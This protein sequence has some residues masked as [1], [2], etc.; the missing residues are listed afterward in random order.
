MGLGRTIFFASSMGNS[1]SQKGHLAAILS[2]S[3]WGETRNSS[4]QPGQIT[5]IELAMIILLTLL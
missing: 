1:F 4:S 5:R 2:L 3:N